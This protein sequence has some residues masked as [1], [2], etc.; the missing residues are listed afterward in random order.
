MNAIIGLTYL[1]RTT[2][3][4]PEQKSKLD[5]I[6]ASGGHLMSVIN[7]VL[8]ISKIE[9]GKFTLD[10]DILDLHAAVESVLAMVTDA[11]AEKG[12][13][14]NCELG[15]APKFVIGDKTRISQCLLNLLGNAIKF[16]AVGSVTVSL[17]VPDESDE[18]A[19][20]RFDVIDSGIGIPADALA[21]L[22]TSFQQVDRSIDLKNV[23]TGLG[24][25]ITRGLAECMGGETGVESQLLAGSRFWFSARLRKCGDESSVDAKHTVTS[26]GTASDET[27]FAGTRVLLVDDNPVNLE[28]TGAILERVGISVTTAQDGLEAI[29][30]LRNSQDSPYAMVL[31]DMEMPRMGG[32]EATLRIRELP[33]GSTIPI[34]AM[35]ANAFGEDRK[36][37]LAAGMN[38][39]LA[40]P[41]A[42]PVFFAMLRKWMRGRH[43]ASDS[44]VATKP[45]MPPP[46]PPVAKPA[47]GLDLRR[48]DE[49]TNGET[50]IMAKVLQQFISHHANDLD[51]LEHSLS[52]GDFQR[53]FQIAHAIKGSAGQIGASDLHTRASAIEVPLRAGTMAA[54]ADLENFSVAFASALEQARDWLHDNLPPTSSNVAGP[55]P[56]PT[57]LLAK[58]KQLQLLLDATDG[59]ALA[60]AEELAAELPPAYGES[61]AP[62]LDLIRR[63][64]LEGAARNM[65]LILPELEAELS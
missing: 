49:M 21:R 45:P 63:F 39:F 32:I 62:V 23:G 61:F 14:L 22:F 27:K 10:D 2:A 54:P 53:A 51:L 44:V 12:I 57:E 28:V 58:L 40:K 48:L 60:A 15:N 11:A 65:K 41:V 13:Q 37:C 34:V 33:V 59:H 7:T 46:P 47:Q 38:D 52:T 30:K 18:D 4:D 43:Q 35:T 42:P 9:A 29:E 50:G 17:S 64:E 16:T 26:E 25:A 8:D 24:L 56:D 3:T 1:L 20:V 19:L 31:M 36:E 55:P 5:R 6:A